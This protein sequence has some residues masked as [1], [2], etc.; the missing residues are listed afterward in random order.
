MEPLNYV[1]A[2]GRETGK[3]FS[4]L[5][6]YRRLR[7]RT[8]FRPGTFDT[9]ITLVNW[10]LIDYLEG[11]LITGDRETHLNEAKELSRCVLYWMQ[12][13]QGWKGLKP[14][15]GVLGT[16]DGFALAPYIRESRRIVARKTITEEEV[17]AE[18]RPGARLAE[19]YEDSVGI[20]SYRID[21]HPSHGGDN[22][23]DVP[24][25]PFRIPLGA[26]LPL[27]LRNL[28]PAAK[29]IGTTHIT[30]GCYRLHPVEWTV[31]E[32]VGEL[33]AF[34]LARRRNPRQVRR[35]EALLK[36]FQAVLTKAGFALAWP[37]DVAKQPR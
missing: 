8:L 11:D 7:D 24:S 35:D 6:T 3:A 2:P 21:L 19:E 27:R 36:D 10:P 33:V 12:R 14:A 15:A 25:L 26:L 1:F 17:S 30:N 31:G 4:G 5:W 29:N 34:A 28:L 13:E 23:V 37:D 9:D 20:G 32:A 18:H 22:Y 16:D